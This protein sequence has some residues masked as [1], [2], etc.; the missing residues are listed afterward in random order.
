MGKMLLPRF[1]DSDIARAC[2][3]VAMG[4]KNYYDYLHTGLWAMVLDLFMLI[5]TR[6]NRMQRKRQRC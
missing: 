5:N 6:S 4:A 1:V 2:G 3:R